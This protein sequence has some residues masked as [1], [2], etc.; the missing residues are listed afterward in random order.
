MVAFPP[1][2]AAFQQVG[3]MSGT[4]SVCNDFKGYGCWVAAIGKQDLLKAVQTMAVPR[5]V[6]DAEILVLRSLEQTHNFL[7]ACSLKFW[8]PLGLSN[9]N[10]SS[11]RSSCAVAESKVQGLRATEVATGHGMPASEKATLPQTTMQP[12]VAPLCRKGVEVSPKP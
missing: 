1:R 9:K 12:H 2:Y 5:L 11:A 6:H 3:V 7:A 8:P 10:T 4:S